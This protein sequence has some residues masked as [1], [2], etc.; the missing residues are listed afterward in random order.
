MIP[1]I[2]L[3]INSFFEIQIFQV[4]AVVKTSTTDYEPAIK[5]KLSEIP[6]AIMNDSYVLS[7]AVLFSYGVSDSDIRHYTAAIKINDKWEI[8]DDMKQKTEEVSNKEVI[9]HAILYLKRH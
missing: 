9:V 3:D 1:N 4:P 6:I 5:H 7:A 2:Q 8:Y